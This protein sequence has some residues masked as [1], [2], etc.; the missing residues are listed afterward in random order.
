[1][2]NEGVRN[3]D[4]QGNDHD[5]VARISHE[6]IRDAGDRAPPNYRILI[7]PRLGTAWGVF[8]RID[9]KPTSTRGNLGQLGRRGNARAKLAVFSVLLS[10]LPTSLYPRF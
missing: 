8:S 6:I 5:Q 7:S 2:S 9:V 4:F 10:R 1:M 3:R